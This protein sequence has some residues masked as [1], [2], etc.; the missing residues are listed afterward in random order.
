MS[1]VKP[2]PAHALMAD[3][4]RYLTKLGWKFWKAFRNPVER[5][6][7]AATDALFSGPN[8][9]VVDTDSMSRMATK[10][11]IGGAKRRLDFGTNSNV[12]HLNY[13]AQKNTVGFIRSA[14]AL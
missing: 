12:H 10:V 1:D 7:D 8:D 11:T 4:T 9:L 2:D 6:A 3:A 5:I 14:F 13:F